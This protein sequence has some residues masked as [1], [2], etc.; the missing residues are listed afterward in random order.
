MIPLVEQR[1]G[2]RQQLMEKELGSKIIYLE[3]LQQLVEQRQEREVQQSRYREAEAAVAALIET[4]AQAEA[5]GSGS[6]HGIADSS[7]RT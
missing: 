1:L 3:T 5:E 2:M 6:D 7:L 4:R